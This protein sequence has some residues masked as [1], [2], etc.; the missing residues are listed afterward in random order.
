M[1]NQALSIYE[2]EF[3]AVT[4]VVQKWKSYLQGHKFIIKTD[5]QALK[6][7]LEQKSMDPT[8]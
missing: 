8:Q 3:L 1:R 5:Q 6:F 2:R 7:L 4:M